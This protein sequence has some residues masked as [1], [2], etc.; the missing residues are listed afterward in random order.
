MTLKVLNNSGSEFSY[1]ENISTSHNGFT[2]E[3]FITKI[4]LT[5]KD[6]DKWYSGIVVK[7]DMGSELPSNSL[8]STT[9]WSVKFLVQDSEPT[10]LEWSRAA[11]NT[12]AQVPDLGSLTGADTSSI[13]SIWIRVFCPGNTAPQVKRNI[14][15]IIDYVENTTSA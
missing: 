8:F 12:E 10:E 1:D 5:N 7:V 11:L 2:G 4:Q 3:A 14:N 13:K 6:E 9:G 15:I